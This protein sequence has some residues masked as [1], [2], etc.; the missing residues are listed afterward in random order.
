MNRRAPLLPIAAAWVAGVGLSLAGL[1]WP[2]AAALPIPLALSPPLAPAAFASL[3]WLAADRARAETWSSEAMPIEAELEGRIASVPAPF[4]DRVRYT[5]RT[6]SG[7]LL[8]ATS[9]PAEW[10]LA[11]GDRVRLLSRLRRPQ[12]PRN[13]GA[14]DQA[15]RLAAVGV[16][17]LADGLLPPVR[18]APPSPLGWL[19]RGRE[20]FAEASATLPPREAALVRAIGTGDR[21]ALD[22]RTNDSFARSGLAHVLAVSGLHLVVVAAG[23]ERLLRGALARVEPLARRWDAR[24]PAAAAALPL[25]LLYA[26]ATGAGFPVVRA[27]IASGL[28]LGATLLDREGR[29]ANTLGLAA[30]AMLAVEPGAL[31]DPSFQLS[32]ASVAGLVALAGPLRRALPVARPPRGT[33]RARLLEPLLGGLCAT[34]AASLAT[35][36]V[37]ALHFRRLPALGVLANLAGVPIGT[38]LTAL[39][40]AAAA[41]AA[42]WPPLAWPLLWVAR[43][44]ASALLLVSDAAAAPDFA[45]IGL[46]SPGPLPAAVACGLAL[47]LARLRGGWRAAAALG[48]AGC[49]A[50]PGPLRA[51]AAARR[52]LLEVL[53]TSTGQSEATLL[54]LPDGAAVLVDGGGT[55]QGGPDPG[56]RDLVPLLRDLGVRRL[57]AV[58]VSHPH[59][60]H[61]LGLAAVAEAFPVD[62]LFLGGNPP[63][64]AAAEALARLPDPER[65]LAGQG[66]EQAGVRFEVL[67][68]RWDELE[69]N[70]GS[71]VL[72]IEHGRV[73][74]LFPGD[75]EAAGEAAALA[76]AGPRLAVDLVKVPHHGSRTS[77]S[78]PFVAA[79]RP[80]H[81]VACVGAG[82]RFGFPHAEAVARWQA[83]GAAFHRTEGGAIRFLSD[84]ARLRKVAAAGAVELRSLWREAAGVAGVEP[85]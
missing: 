4:G 35:A 5:L 14:A 51:W 21:A 55:F 29:A 43:P 37:L 27:A 2:P 3:G 30:A 38:A 45:V 58:V 16:A 41:L 47:S 50:L 11:L 1:R 26:L 33:W 13:P 66:W 68:H 60:D 32:L 17:R 65:L 15:E 9:P 40:A 56:A 57:S 42:A 25:V 31:L 84:G 71:M 72:R 76:A 20:R 61:V 18:V 52:G 49:L 6:R 7:E 24:R 82:N 69:G 79:V 22:Q 78:P 63:T 48:L 53:F 39:T 46:A 10:P 59:P 19:E 74:L 36:P 81:A 73:A 54:R 62:R 77:S 28:L 75:V 23:L 85:P 80:A 34:L 8:E 67:S 83:A 70:D 12:G 64:G 44:F